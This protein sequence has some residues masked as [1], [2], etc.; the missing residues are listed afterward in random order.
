MAMETNAPKDAAPW[1]LVTGAS[2]GIG[3]ATA[4]ELAR[5]GYNLVISARRSDLLEDLAA[6]LIRE[7]SREV[8]II[9]ADLSSHEGPALLDAETRDLNLSCV[10]FAAGYGTS[11]SFLENDL[12]TELRMVDLNC[13]AVVDSAHRFSRRMRDKN[14]KGSIVLFSSLVGFQGVPRAA[15]YA[16]TKAFVQVLA[17]GLK[18]ELVPL[19]INV[20]AVAPGPV[21]S[22]FADVAGMTMGK[23]ATP[24]EVAKATVKKLGSSGTIRPGFLSKF[25]E[26]GLFM[27]PRRGRTTVMKAVMAGMTANRT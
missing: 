13:R 26:F 18:H 10:V 15:N 6:K 19:G 16:A 24:Q 11:G 9:P 17:E 27:L 5:S 23:A 14:T 20:I 21:N 4:E 7:T 1:A 12:E 8:R 2:D 3:R 22:G 25:L